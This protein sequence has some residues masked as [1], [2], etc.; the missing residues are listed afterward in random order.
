VV[1]FVPSLSYQP[2]KFAGPCFACSAYVPESLLGST[3]NFGCS[4][5]RILPRFPAPARSP[6]A[7]AG[8]PPA[9]AAAPIPACSLGLSPVPRS[10][11]PGPFPSRSPGGSLSPARSGL[12]RTRSR[13]PGPGPSR[14]PAARPRRLCG[15]L[16]APAPGPDSASRLGSLPAPG[17]ASPRLARLPRLGLTRASHVAAQPLPGGSRWISPGEAPQSLS[18]SLGPGGSASLG[19]Q[20]LGSLG[21]S[22]PRSPAPAP[23]RGGPSP[24]RCYPVADPVATGEFHG[25]SSQVVFDQRAD[26]THVIIEHSLSVARFAQKQHQCRS[27]RRGE[28]RGGS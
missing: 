17:S 7:R 24:A 2:Q 18:Q 14:S 3:A 25:C 26:H 16:S 27:K 8:S 20:R 9:R 10:L 23:V 6:A 4:D 19:S 15:S 13:L 28:A 11:A 21:P 1:P 12:S 5:L 22:R